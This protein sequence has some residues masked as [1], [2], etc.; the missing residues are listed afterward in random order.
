MGVPL[1]W[2]RHWK[3]VAGFALGVVAMIAFAGNERV[4]AITSSERGDTE[5]AEEPA[6][7]DL[8]GTVDV[9]DRTRVHRIAIEF[10]QR[11]YQ[12]MLEAFSETE[13]KQFIQATVTIDGTRIDTTG[14]RLKGNSTLRGLGGGFGGFGGGARVSAAEPETL[15]WLVEF[16]TYVEDSRYQGYETLAI[17]PS[18]GVT[19]STGLNEALATSLIAAVGEPAVRFSY[20]SVTINGGEPTLRLV[21]EE[22]DTKFAADNFV[23]EGVLYK[24]LSTGGFEYR[25]EDPV[26]YADSFRQITRKGQQDLQPVIKLLRWV[27]NAS[28]KE[29]DAELAQHVD[30]DSFARYVALQNLLLNFDDMAGP[31]QN[32]YLWYEL[33]DERLRVLTWDLNFALSGDTGQG[34]FEQGRFGFGGRFPG[35]VDAGGQPAFGGGQQDGAQRRPVPGFGGGTGARGGNLLKERFLASD[36]FRELYLAEYRKVYEELFVSGRARRELERL[37]KVLSSSEAIDP[38]RLEA[39]GSELV[40]TIQS[41]RRELASVLEED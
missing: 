41:R 7:L 14:L 26:A 37:Q 36:A 9:F 25:G 23:S 22:P 24:A 18:T 28:D 3:L 35:G 5:S 16:D 40:T 20:A 38:A 34:P 19:P 2:R 30:V 27:T 32:Y 21:L 33:K 8:A 13:M 31:G 1:R 4:T 15:P 12:R 17:R 11:D 6:G 39:E 10:E 29:F